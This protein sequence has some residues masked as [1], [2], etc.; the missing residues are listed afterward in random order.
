MILLQLLDARS[1]NA[2]WDKADAAS[3]RDGF[4]EEQPSP[5]DIPD[6][7]I[8]AIPDIGLGSQGSVRSSDSHRKTPSVN[9]RTSP[10][11]VEEVVRDDQVS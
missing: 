1:A 6:S 11:V 10:D 2:E 7:P 5:S 8:L 4:W 9:H 3:T